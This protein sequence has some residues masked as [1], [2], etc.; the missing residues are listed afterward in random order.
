[1]VNDDLAARVAALE[2]RVDAWESP[3][4]AAAAEP[5]W[6]LERLK[7]DVVPTVGEQGAVLFT[8]SVTLPTGERAEWQEGRGVED[9]LAADWSTFVGGLSA[10]AHPVR[11]MLLRRVLGG[12]RSVTEL[13]EHESLG[14]TGQLY[15]HLRQ[16]TAAGWLRATARGR[17]E[18][19]AERVV[20]LLVVLMGAGR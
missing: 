2:A 4:T 19:P 10:L 11:L 8:G 9:L 17:Y 6:A 18:V 15:H 13:G 14:T 1:M 5:L 16:L 12:T 3:R 20:P 7:R